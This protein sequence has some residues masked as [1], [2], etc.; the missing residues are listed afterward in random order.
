MNSDMTFMWYH[1]GRNVSSDTSHRSGNR[2]KSTLAVPDVSDGEVRVVNIDGSA[3]RKAAGRPARSG[4]DRTCTARS[5]R[6]RPRHRA[7]SGD[8]SQLH[9]AP[10]HFTNSRDSLVTLLVSRDRGQEVASICEAVRSDGTAL[11]QRER[12]AIVLAQ[13][14]ARRLARQFDA[15]LHAARH[16]HDLTGRRV[17]DAELGP[18]AQRTLLEN[19]QH[20][21]V[22]VVEILVLHGPRDRVDVARHSGLRTDVAGRG[23][24]ADALD[25]RP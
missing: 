10:P 17:D 16:D 14:A 20:F 12:A 3:D 24:R 8:R 6:A 23:D 4:A 1:G 2:T 22:A 25:E 13:V 19:D 11:R 21:P 15:Q 5:Y 7:A 9:I 18:E